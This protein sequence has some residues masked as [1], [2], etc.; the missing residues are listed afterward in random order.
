MGRRDLIGD[1]EVL[2]GVPRDFLLSNI[3]FIMGVGLETPASSSSTEASF[4][5]DICTSED[6]ARARTGLE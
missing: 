6:K 3:C 5:L 1:F 4:S 2:R